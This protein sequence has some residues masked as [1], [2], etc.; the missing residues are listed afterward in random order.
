MAIRRFRILVR[1]KATR[2]PASNRFCFSQIAIT[3]DEWQMHRAHFALTL[4]GALVLSGCWEGISREVVA[5][6][7]S[8]RGET[9]YSQQGSTNSA[10]I[11]RRTLLSGGAVLRTASDGQLDLSLVPGAL[12][13]VPANSELRI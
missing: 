4:I 12:A 2:D 11:N 5:T 7:L 9:V 6:V 1:R 8:I 3:R 10:P 13:R